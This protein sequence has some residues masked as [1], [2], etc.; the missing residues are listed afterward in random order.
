MVNNKIKGYI[1]LYLYHMLYKE[2]K[3]LQLYPLAGWPSSLTIP[4][5]PTKAAPG[6][7]ASAK[8]PTT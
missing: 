4:A 7:W 2:E 5:L 8:A 3:T 6:Y 1:S